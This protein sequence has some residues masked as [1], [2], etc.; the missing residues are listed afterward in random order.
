M[1]RTLPLA[2]PHAAARVRDAALAAQGWTRRYMTA[3]P[4][5]LEGAA[6]YRELGFEVRLEHPNSDELREECDDCRLALELFRV[7]YTRKIP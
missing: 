3:G 6:L 2:P 4:R 1:V 7:L 5:A